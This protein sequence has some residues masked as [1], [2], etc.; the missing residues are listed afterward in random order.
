MK[1]A[2]AWVLCAAW[3]AVIFIM[4]ATPGE[5]SDMQSG[6]VVALLPGAMH[7][8]GVSTSVLSPAL[9]YVLEVLLRKGAHM[10]EYALLFWLFLHALRV[11]GVRHPG[12]TALLLTAA[13]A[14]TDEFHQLFVAGRL[15]RLS[16][17][18]IDIAGAGF[19]W[20]AALV[21][22]RIR[23]HRKRPS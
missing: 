15:G 18:L 21:F 10:A 20:G 16:D 14:S 17:V 1:K 6:S 9:L 4:S 5:V 19:G 23:A 22:E 7:A 12:L 11:S 8:M 3:M 13:Y 2:A